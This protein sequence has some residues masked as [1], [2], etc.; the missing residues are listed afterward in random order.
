MDFCNQ[1][2]PV[3]EDH[4]R[5]ALAK[6]GVLHITTPILEEQF[7]HLC[8]QL[9]SI[10]ST[11]S[12][13]VNASAIAQEQGSRADNPKLQRPTIYSNSSIGYHTDSPEQDIIAWRCVRQDVNDGKLY[14]LDTANIL[15]HFSVTELQEMKAI[16]LR[17]AKRVDSIEQLNETALLSESDSGSFQVYYTP[18]FLRTKYS[19]I[20]QAH[21][22]KFQA[23]IATTEADVAIRLLPGE[24]LFVDNRRMLHAREAI[25]PDSKRQITRIGIKTNKKS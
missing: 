5:E 1:T 17:W 23:W 2:F 19:P 25:A 18:W 16:K 3:T 24:V 6:N 21:I 20:E 8:S 14:L 22:E 9:G 15:K 10:I 13:E 11:A 12:V 4:I 7:G